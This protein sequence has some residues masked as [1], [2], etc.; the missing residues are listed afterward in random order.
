MPDP[1]IITSPLSSP[2]TEGNIIVVI[3]IYRFQDPKWSLEVI[4]SKGTCDKSG[5]RIISVGDRP[6]RI[7]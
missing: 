7:D 5:D 1:T 3:Q 2:F 6:I 4:D